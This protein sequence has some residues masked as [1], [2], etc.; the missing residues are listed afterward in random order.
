MVPIGSSMILCKVYVCL[1]SEAGH[2]L[3][4]KFKYSQTLR[5]DLELSFVTQDLLISLAHT[6]ISRVGLGKK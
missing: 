3:K 6:P 1:F 2:S 4:G 5:K